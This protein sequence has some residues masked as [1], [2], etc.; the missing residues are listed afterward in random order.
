MKGIS[1][2]GTFYRRLNNRELPI[3]KT[4]KIRHFWIFSAPRERNLMSIGQLRERPAAFY[5]VIRI[6]I[7]QRPTPP[8][9]ITDIDFAEYAEPLR[10]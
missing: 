7:P 9:P 4:G 2:P 6:C 1:P 8:L 10:Q 3:K 5:A